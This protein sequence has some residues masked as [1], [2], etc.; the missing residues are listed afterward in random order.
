MIKAFFFLKICFWEELIENINENIE[1][2][3]AID[4]G[5]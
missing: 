4:Q 5:Y 1:V 3:K 2:I